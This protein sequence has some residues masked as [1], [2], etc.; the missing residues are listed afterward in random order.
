MIAFFSTVVD[1]EDMKT[2]LEQVEGS[3]AGYAFHVAP[4]R[5]F[6]GCCAPY[7]ESKDFE[8]DCRQAIIDAERVRD[9]LADV[10]LSWE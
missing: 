1:D 6:V 7:R 4:E 3:I 2:V 9:M 10:E 8:Q 5:W